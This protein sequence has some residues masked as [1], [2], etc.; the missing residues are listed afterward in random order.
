MQCHTFSLSLAWFWAIFNEL[1]SITV[2]FIKK[3]ISIFFKK[4]ITVTRGNRCK[5][6]Y[7]DLSKLT[8]TLS[9]TTG[10]LMI[11]YF[12]FQSPK[13]GKSQRKQSVLEL[14]VEQSNLYANQIGRN[15]TVTK[16][17]L[18]AFLGINFIMASNKL[19]TMLNTGEQIIWSVM[20]VFRTQ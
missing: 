12:I 11:S 1:P 9:S 16:E 3:C 6:Q 13:L 18:K 10:F 19:P 14:I 8:S 17:K 15:F 5:W 7:A 20:T 4:K 2:K